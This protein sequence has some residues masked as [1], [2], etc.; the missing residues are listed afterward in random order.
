MRSETLVSPFARSLWRDYLKSHPRLSQ[1]LA[2]G[3]V[4]AGGDGQVTNCCHCEGPCG[5]VK[6]EPGMVYE[7]PKVFPELPE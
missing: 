7:W 2:S 4:V 3:E 1:T 5:A 6:C